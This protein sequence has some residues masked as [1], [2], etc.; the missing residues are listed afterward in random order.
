[1]LN[2]RT[3]A[4]AFALAVALAAS[5]AAALAA[6]ET[7]AASKSRVVAATS[8]SLDASAAK[9]R[10]KKKKKGPPAV[11]T[12]SQ[13]SFASGTT[14]PATAHCPA[15][16]HVTGGGFN[17][18]PPFTP[19]S[20]GLRSVTSTSHPTGPAG[21]HA[22]GSAFFTPAA[23]GS[24]TTHA[25]CESNSLGK[26]AEIISQTITLA[27]ASAQTFTF[28]CPPGTHAL[29]G[30]YAGAGTAGFDYPP[31]MPPTN[32]RIIP[33]QSRRTSPTQWT[34]QALNSS[35]SPAAATF[36]GYA[37]CERDA[38]GR[39][40]SE[41]S[42]FVA[43]INDSRA[44]GDPTCAGRKQHV[45]SGGFLI[46]PNTVGG[47]PATAI[48]EFQP[49]G[50]GTWHLGLHELVNRGLPAGSSLQTY[51]YCAPDTLKKKKKKRKR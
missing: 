46:F 29:S 37:V 23:A 27:P 51:A 8:D 9:K 50:K 22:S 3:A 16:T 30:G 35:A 45:V 47:V 11:T 36:T 40:I 34:V 44:S 4:I 20:T 6:K 41:A 48:D 18:S 49:V 10:K 2:R 38:K 14:V 42:T 39:T 25:R 21:W 13:L 7:V 43:L 5:P 17:V 19:P 33:L 31:N 26:F 12:S 15:R 32:L 1:M 24:F 28:S